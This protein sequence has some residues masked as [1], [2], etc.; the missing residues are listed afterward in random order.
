MADFKLGI[1]GSETTLPDILYEPGDELQADAEDSVEEDEMMD[2]S[3]RYDFKENV[4]RTWPLEW[5]DLTWAQ[6]GTLAGIAALK[7]ELNYINGYM[8]ITGATVVVAH[9]SGAILILETSGLAAPLYR[10][11]MTLKEVC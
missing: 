10:A 5:A 8:G 3:F 4:R 6:I 9:W 7:Q 11:S 1:L 2:G